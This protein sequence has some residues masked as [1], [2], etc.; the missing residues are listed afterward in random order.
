ML[1]SHGKT[2]QLM[3]MQDNDKASALLTNHRSLSATDHVT[4]HV[5][6]KVI[7]KHETK[8]M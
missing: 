8:L 5:Q 2:I 7:S 6:S 1:S 3:E 4:Q